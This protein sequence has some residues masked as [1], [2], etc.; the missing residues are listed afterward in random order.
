MNNIDRIKISSKL[1]IGFRLDHFLTKNLTEYSRSQI[2]L[3]IRSG[4]ILV[5]NKNCKT[6]YA[7]ESNDTISIFH[8]ERKK[9]LS[10]ISPEPMN[11]EILY[12]DE[13]IAVINKP[14]GMVVHPGK[15][16]TSKTLANGIVHHFNHLSNVNGLTRPGIVHRLDKDTSGLILIAKSN[17]AHNMLSEQFKNRQVKKEYCA[18]TW[19]L[20]KE[21]EG[22][23]ED[24]LQR[25][26]KD[27]TRFC[28]S[29]NGKKSITQF[30]IYKEFQ[31]CS[32]IRFFPK[33]GRTHQIRVHSAHLGHPIFG[34]E[35]YGGGLSK[36]KGFI[37]EYSSAY[38]KLML[39]FD[40]YG[41]HAKKLEF[42]HPRSKSLVNFE[43]KLPVEF[44][45]LIKDLDNLPGF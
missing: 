21:K 29:E 1:D 15:G 3:L 40:R 17:S 14:S 37:N 18:L 10:T 43:S 5:N 19:G 2:Q 11:L 23:I 36:T 33:T 20:W 31:H 30:Q 45:N 13:D 41:L 32:L 6:G 8:P 7:L 26:R 9:E 35:K 27:P 39:N 22:Q 4:K 28:I 16:N 44:I 12:E 38:Q 24:S 34:D 25:D 42:F